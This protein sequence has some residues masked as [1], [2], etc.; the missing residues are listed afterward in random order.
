MPK[1][2]Q[3]HRARRQQQ[4]LDGARRCFAERGYEGTTI[5]HLEAAINLSSG[6]ILN[7]YPSKLQLFIALASEDAQQAARLWQQGGLRA[8]VRYRAESAAYSASYLELGRR[9]WADPAFR[10]A[11]ARRGSPLTAAIRRDIENAVNEGRL[12][13]DMDVDELFDFTTVVL[14]G[15]MLG[16]RTGMRV[17]R[18]E[19]MVTLYEEAVSAP[20]A[21]T[22]TSSRQ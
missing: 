14:D 12:R 5:R 7:Y 4:I 20:D 8:L 11:W 13:R 2:S 9:I 17:E 22:N 3:Q 19:A 1:M 21:M 16:I 15:I 6:A 18:L 10:E